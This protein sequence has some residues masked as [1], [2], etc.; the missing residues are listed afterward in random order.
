MPTK[1][2]AQVKHMKENYTQ[3]AIRLRP[4]ILTAFKAKCAKNGTTPTTELKKF[5]NHYIDETA[6]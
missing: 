4:E 1:Y 6:L 2:N 5:I 3:F